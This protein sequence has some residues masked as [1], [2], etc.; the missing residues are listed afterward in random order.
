MLYKL[1]ISV[2]GD[3]LLLCEGCDLRYPLKRVSIYNYR[4]YLLR[5]YKIL[6][7]GYRSTT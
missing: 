3:S 5:S 2:I 4:L 6:A 1:L 7:Y